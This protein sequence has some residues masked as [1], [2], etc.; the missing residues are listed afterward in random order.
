MGG[1]DAAEGIT[2]YDEVDESTVFNGGYLPG[3]G[4]G[5][6]TEGR[7]RGKKS[8]ASV[9]STHRSKP[10]RPMGRGISFR[11][12]AF[13]FRGFEDTAK[14]MLAVSIGALILCAVILYL[15]ARGDAPLNFYGPLAASVV[16]MAL[17][18]FI[19]SRLIGNNR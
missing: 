7:R 16:V 15:T 1:L 10:K 14:L 18:F 13:N 8:L 12:F 2:G 5:Q 4:K 19:A 11:S 6:A 17:L 9:G 3:A